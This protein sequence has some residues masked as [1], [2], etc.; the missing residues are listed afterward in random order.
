M[1]TPPIPAT[2]TPWPITPAPALA[3]LECYQ[4][5]PLIKDYNGPSCAYVA[6]P[7]GG[8]TANNEG[9]RFIECDYWSGQMMQEFYNELQS[10]QGAGVPQAQPPGARDTV[11]EIERVLHMVER[12]TRGRFHAV[13][14]H[15][16]QA[17]R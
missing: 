2:A 8:Y 13:A 14:R 12:P 17:R 9:N 11:A 4:I 7:F 15:R 1:R 5:N 6:G 16:L 10:G 3:N